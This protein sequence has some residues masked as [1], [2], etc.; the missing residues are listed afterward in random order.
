[1]KWCPRSSRCCSYEQ[2]RLFFD[3]DDVEKCLANL[4][5][6]QMR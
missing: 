4:D 1:M 3:A 2:I 5:Q 6:T